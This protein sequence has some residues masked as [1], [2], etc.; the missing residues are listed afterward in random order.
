MTV[1]T[2]L[3]LLSAIVLISNTMSTLVAEQ[4]REIAVMR[5][6]GARR[7]QVAL[8]YARTALLLGAL[9]ALTGTLLGIG[10]AYLLARS[11]GHQFWAIDVGFGV[12]PV[13]WCS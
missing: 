12:A 7:R 4:T 3:A 5:A 10:L 6:V 9:G 13:P 1:I 8:I 11:F 2:I